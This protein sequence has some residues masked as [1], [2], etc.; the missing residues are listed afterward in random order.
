MADTNTSKLTTNSYR[1]IEAFYIVGASIF[2]IG[3]FAE[4]HQVAFDFAWNPYVIAPAL[5]I[6]LYA[7]LLFII[8]R[9]KTRNRL[10]FWY[11]LIILL[12]LIFS[13]GGQITKLLSTNL[14]TYTFWNNLTFPFIAALA[15]PAIVI[16]ILVYLGREAIFF[17]ISTWVVVFGTAL[18][19]F[20]LIANSNII[21][22]VAATQKHFYGYP[23]NP[24]YGK[25][26][27]L[28]SLL[29]LAVFV[30]LI[31]LLTRYQ[32]YLPKGSV[33]RK[34]ALLLLLGISIPI[35]LGMITGAVL[36][37]F[38]VPQLEL[39]TFGNLISVPLI[40]YAITRYRLFRIDPAT[41]STTVLSTMDESVVTI[42]SDY[43]IEDLNTSSSKLFSTEVSASRGQSLS[44]LFGQQNADAIISKLKEGVLEPFDLT[45]DLPDK[46]LPIS[47]LP[48]KI[49]GAD[50]SISGYV[51]VFRD[52][53]AERAA[54]EVVE[55][56]VEL[57]TKQL[58]EEQAR[59]QASINSLQL[60]YIMASTDGVIMLINT[61]AQSILFGGA[62]KALPVTLKELTSQLSGALDLEKLNQECVSK[63]APIDMAEL[64]F[65]P[66][67]LHTFL[68]P[69]TIGE[70]KRIIGSV[71]ILEDITDAKALD[72][73]R[74]E[75]FSIASHELRT[76]LTAIQGNMSLLKNYYPEAIER[77]E[78]HE[79]VD[80][81]YDSTQ[82]LIQIVNDF[83]D[84]SRLE[85][86]RLHFEIVAI[87]PVELA[88][89]VVH[90]FNLANSKPE[91]KLSLE[92]PKAP[93]SAVLADKIRFRQIIVNLIGN[94]IKFTEQGTI[95]VS[96]SQEHGAVKMSVTD[97]GRGIPVDKQHLL[98]RKFQQ[99]TDDIL[100]RDNTRSTGLGLYVS[101]LMIENMSGKVWLEKSEDG[102]GSTFSI[103]LPAAPAGAQPAVAPAAPAETK[104]PPHA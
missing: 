100:T 29:T 33:A 57:R 94:A 1:L 19:S 76:P 7:W 28:F 93:I 4:N 47:L 75:F 50:E 91:V 3:Y 69:I 49:L 56:E 20:F 12:T 46:Q 97:S 26:G 83:L 81:V 27:Q 34:Q 53:T 64:P 72:R 79:I 17:R 98:F 48:S 99:A 54:K 89:D 90:E 92:P 18:M 8:N 39:D 95:V 36:P 37:I 96:F 52:V 11:T 15:A 42:S 32:R 38:H 23:S 60:G 68:A 63:G 9:K 102:K 71:I 80:D 58:H 62:P 85:Q 104:E 21:F 74:D 55:H 66:K 61:A 77:P 73:S 24:A 101:K 5:S 41:L 78:I 67:F 86:G 45:I 40:A 44:T 43:E 25:Y 6:P 30:T 51:L 2:V 22:D 16:F 70:P 103:S 10:T 31:V 84:T 13:T 82:R 88:G 87:D 59:L 35:M 14:A 65:G